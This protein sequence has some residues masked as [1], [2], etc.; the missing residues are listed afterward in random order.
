MR[1]HWAPT[2]ARAGRS[3]PAGARPPLACARRRRRPQGWLEHRLSLGVTEG[4]AELGQD[5][6]LWLECNAAELNG[7][8]FNKGCYV[9]QENTA[10]MNWRQ[11]VNRRLVVVADRRA[12][13]AHAHPLSGA[14]AGGRASPHR[15]S[16]R[17]DRARLAGRRA[18]GCPRRPADLTFPPSDACLREESSWGDW[19][20]VQGRAFSC[21]RI[22]DLRHSSPRRVPR[23]RPETPHRPATPVERGPASGLPAASR[24]SAP[25]RSCALSFAGCTPGVRPIRRRRRHRRLRRLRRHR[26]PHR[27]DDHASPNSVGEDGITNV[28]E[29]GVDEGGIVKVPATSSSSCAGDDFSP[30]R[31]PMAACARSTGSTPVRPARNRAAIGMMKC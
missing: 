20:D 3:A 17:R 8:S 2:A 7:V 10:R 4:A 11:K 31:S 29:A 19:C 27:A 28:Q 30:S 21:L 12:G 18:R 24:R 1:V 5:K 26:P 14:R 9:G 13:R 16:R 25:T 6:T 15:R 22:E 23:L